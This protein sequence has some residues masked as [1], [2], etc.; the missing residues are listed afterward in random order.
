MGAFKG[1]LQLDPMS[2]GY[3]FKIGEALAK[4]GELERLSSTVNPQLIWGLT[5]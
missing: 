3:H 4:K 1:A 2:P 5:M